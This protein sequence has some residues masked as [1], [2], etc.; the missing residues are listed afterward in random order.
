MF[1][2][3]RVSCAG[4]LC[5]HCLMSPRAVSAGSG[6]E[7]ERSCLAHTGESLGWPNGGGFGLCPLAC[8]GVSLQPAFVAGKVVS[9]V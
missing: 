9:R 8:H 5:V 1:K 2:G 4:G 6:G 7:G 3:C